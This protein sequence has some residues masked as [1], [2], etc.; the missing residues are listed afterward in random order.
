[1]EF[2]RINAMILPPA[3]AE[4]LANE[5][6]GITDLFLNLGSLAIEVIAISFFRLFEKI[7]EILSS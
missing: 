1:M 2:D 7:D 6:M 5:K 4:E 3:T